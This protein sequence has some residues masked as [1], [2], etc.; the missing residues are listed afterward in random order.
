[1]WAAGERM[2]DLFQ[3][4][5]RETALALGYSFDASEARNS[6][7]FF[8]RVRRLPRDAKEIF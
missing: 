3:R 4:I 7:A 8:D 5:Q 2:C 1:M 6:R